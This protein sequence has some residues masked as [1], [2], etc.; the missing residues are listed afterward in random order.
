MLVVTHAVTGAVIGQL[1]KNSP[2][3]FILGVVVHFLMD[4]IPH[5]DSADYKKFKES[6]TIPKGRIYQLLFD[7]VIMFGLIMYLLIFKVDGYWWPTFWGIIG[8]ILPDLMVGVHECRPSRFSKPLH[9]LHFKFHDIITD[10]WKD[11]RL[12]YSIIL[13]LIA[14]VIVVSQFI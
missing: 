1:V 8:S 14:L 7:N 4:M 10:R 2:I 6:N 12:R 11:I 9:R 5:G 3:S 13:Q